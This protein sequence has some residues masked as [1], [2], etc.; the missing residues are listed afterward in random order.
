[1]DEQYIDAA[2]IQI[3]PLIG[4]IKQVIIMGEDPGCA[5]CG[6]PLKGEL[7][8]FVSR[9]EFELLFC[10]IDCMKLKSPPQ[11]TTRNDSS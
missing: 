3:P 4:S 8:W 11:V 2:D 9:P 7:V 5:R 10:S 6:R 1:M